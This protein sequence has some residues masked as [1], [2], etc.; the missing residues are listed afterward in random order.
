M[1]RKTLA[2]AAALAALAALAPGRAG[3]AGPSDAPQC[4][5]QC[6]ELDDMQKELFEQEFMQARFQKYLE[7]DIVPNPQFV[8][9][10]QTGKKVLE[11]MIDAMQREAAEALSRYMGSP[12]GGGSSGTAAPAA[13]TTEECTIKVIQ[14]GKASPWDDKAYRKAHPCWD[15][16]YVL[17]H[18]QQH[19]AD[20]K[21]GA[22]IHKDYR[23]YAASDVR[24]Y[25]VGIRSLRKQIAATAKRCGWRGSVRDDGTEIITGKNP[26]D[27]QDQQV[28][29]TPAE[30][31]QI[32]DALKTA[33][34]NGRGRK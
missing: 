19:V 25:G 6:S 28:V 18:E 22:K 33:P 17:G 34:A 10:P 31:K 8:I 3:A 26:V 15:A 20:C 29:P 2:L 11:T 32:V 13:G 23:V 27:G 24:A 7:L 14:N 12:A 16:D 5:P 21:A 30:V 1:H 4:K 9:D